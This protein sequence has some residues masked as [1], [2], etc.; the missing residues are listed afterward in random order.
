MLEKIKKAY[1]QITQGK[2]GRRFTDYHQSQQAET[3]QFWKTPLYVA[4][5]LTLVVIGTFLSIPPG[6]PGFFITIPGL[7]LIAARLEILA[8][9]LDR[10][11]LWLRRYQHKFR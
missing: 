4:A 7:M 1:F 3:Q 6:I 5:G 10:S 8:R 11:E 2:P 9:F